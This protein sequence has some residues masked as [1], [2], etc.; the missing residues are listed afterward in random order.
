MGSHHLHSRAAALHRQEC[1]PHTT[2]LACYTADARKWPE[3]RICALT[4]TAKAQAKAGK[5]EMGNDSSDILP[6]KKLS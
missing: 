1:N 4:M 5:G 3:M 6:G 2:E